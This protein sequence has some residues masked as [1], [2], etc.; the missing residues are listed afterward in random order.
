MKGID[1]SA[2]QPNVD[3]EKVKAAGIEVVYIKATEG[4]SY[5][6][7]YLKKH[8]AAAKAAGL[9]VGFYHFFKWK[10]QRTTMI[11]NKIL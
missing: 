2:Y 7:P 11:F 6:N 4:T 8:A 5:I 1:I 3:F 10:S 9:K